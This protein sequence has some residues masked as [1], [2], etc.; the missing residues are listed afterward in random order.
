MKGYYMRLLFILPLLLGASFAHAAQ[1]ML[2]DGS[3]REAFVMEAPGRGMTM[4]EVEQ[5]FGPPLERRE[6]VGDPPITRWFYADYTV[7][8]EHQYVIRAVLR[9]H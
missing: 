9:R 6:P 1:V 4:A 8:F 7:Y 3:M 2:P 5:R